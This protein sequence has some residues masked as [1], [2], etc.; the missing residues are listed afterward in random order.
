MTKTEIVLTIGLAG[1]VIQVK[2]DDL[3]TN[4]TNNFQQMT[5]RTATLI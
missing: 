3:Q 2:N 5:N 4:I 1:C